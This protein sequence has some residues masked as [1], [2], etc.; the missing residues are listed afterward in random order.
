MREEEACHGDGTIFYI[1]V[2]VHIVQC[3]DFIRIRMS[4]HRKS[5]ISSVDQRMISIIGVIVLTASIQKRYISF[6]SLL[7]LSSKL[8][9][10]TPTLTHS[11]FFSR[12]SSER[13]R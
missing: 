8:D 4:H 5:I 1:D 11:Q 13:D 3:D 2:H 7:Q 6:D 10:P 9:D 12:E